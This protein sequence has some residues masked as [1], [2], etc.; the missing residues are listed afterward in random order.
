MLHPNEPTM[1][2]LKKIRRELFTKTS[3]PEDLKKLK[4]IDLQIL[5]HEKEAAK[6]NKIS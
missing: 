6:N 1:E 4:A 3:N 5:R 2:E